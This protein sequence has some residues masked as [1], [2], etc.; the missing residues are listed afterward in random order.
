MTTCDSSG[1][2]VV[3]KLLCKLKSHFG[4]YPHDNIISTFAEF[5]IE[6]EI[7]DGERIIIKI[8]DKCV[9]KLNELKKIKGRVRN[10]K[11]KR[12]IEDVL[13]VYTLLEGKK[14]SLP[15]MLASD[16]S[17]IPTLILI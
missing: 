8:A 7:V 2:Y 9:P 13:N 6:K 16:A 10:G 15:R 11:L 12:D 1:G 5:Y 3:N 17:R 14:T 4:K